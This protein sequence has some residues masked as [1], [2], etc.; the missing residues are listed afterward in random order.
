METPE[1]SEVSEGIREPARTGERAIFTIGHVALPADRFV[2][3]LRQHD[4]ALLVDIR[5]FPGSRKSPQF[6]PDQLRRTLH[7]AG[8]GYVHLGGLGGR[9]RPLPDSP[10]CAWRNPSFRG[11]ADYME[12]G[13][14]HEALKELMMLASSQRVVIMCAEAVWWRCH[15]SMVADALAVQGW[16]VRHIMSDG[17]VRPHRLTAPARIVDGALTYRASGPG[18]DAGACPEPAGGDQGAT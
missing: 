16:Q 3:L 14:F 5:R 13:E 11:Y 17:A 10:N 1:L 18:D 12:T 7:D 4:I 8:I 2:E 9:R 15:R 6:D